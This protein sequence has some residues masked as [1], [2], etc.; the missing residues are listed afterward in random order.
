[1]MDCCATQGLI[2]VETALET[3]LSQVSPISST[4]TLAL[5]DAIGFVLAEDICSPINV[6]PFANSAMDGYAVRI[7]DLEQSLTLPL[8]GKSFAGTP[9]E[10]QWPEKTTIRI[11]TGAK[12]PEGC[13]AVIMQ[14]LTSDSEGNITFDLA[15]ADVKPQTNIRPIGDDVAQGQT[16]LAKGHRLTPRDIPL[17]ASLGKIGRAHV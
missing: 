12:I 10:G 9:F 6:P 7:S 1:M 16:V 11:M 17:I 3:L 2:P 4:S 14:E 13:D 8:T 5:A 15:L